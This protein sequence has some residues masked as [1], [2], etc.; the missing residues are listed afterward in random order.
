MLRYK[1]A[2]S[3]A[4][5]S[6]TYLSLICVIRH[7]TATIFDW[8]VSVMNVFRHGIVDSSSRQTGSAVPAKS[9]LIDRVATFLRNSGEESTTTVE[10][11]NDT[12][13]PSVTENDGEKSTKTVTKKETMRP[14]I[15]ENQLAL[16]R[17]S[18]GRCSDVVQLH[19]VVS[20]I[21]NSQTGAQFP[22]MKRCVSD[23]KALKKKAL[24]RNTRKCRRLRR[25]DNRQLLQR[26]VLIVQE[27]LDVNRSDFV[28]VGR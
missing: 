14:S 26:G 7:S 8:L 4:E 23:L 5:K 11:T 16:W 25:R 10:K 21:S 13:R 3:V 6:E 1:I 19:L 17:E 15:T 22:G 12:V 24:Q 28:I 2:A 18:V 20:R 27:L 9:P